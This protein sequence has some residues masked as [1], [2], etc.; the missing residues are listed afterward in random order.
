MTGFA[1]LVHL[2]E[3]LE[4]RLGDDIL[5]YPGEHPSFVV[6]FEYDH[7]PFALVHPQ[8]D[9]A[10]KVTLF[11]RFGRLPEDRKAEVLQRLMEINFMSFSDAMATFSL[12]PVEQD[13]MYGMQADLGSITSDSI[14]DTV[15]RLAAQADEWNDTFYLEQTLPGD[16][17]SLN[18]RI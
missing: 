12:D 15:R 2:T 16:E 1:T 9:A 11:C 6:E 18:Q 4:R 3:E 17:N 8:S 7:V 14:I 10:H 13:V 5:I